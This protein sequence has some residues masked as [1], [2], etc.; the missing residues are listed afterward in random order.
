MSDLLEPRFSLCVDYPGNGKPIGYVYKE[1]ECG[2]DFRRYPEIF[3]EMSWE[4]ER[5][6]A[7]MPAYLKHVLT[8]EVKKVYKHFTY[9]L[10]GEE[11]KID[12]VCSFDEITGKNEHLFWRYDNTLPATELDFIV[13]KKKIE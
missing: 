13:W 6:V 2:L 12:A 4:E 9:I 8:G 10:Y 1:G 11:H 3:R 5:L 7:E